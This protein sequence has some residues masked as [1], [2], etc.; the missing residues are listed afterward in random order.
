MSDNKRNKIDSVIDEVIE[1]KR[2][3]QGTR[4][5]FTKFIGIVVL[6]I[7]LFILAIAM[8]IIR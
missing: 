6:L 2:L 4:F 5:L 1:S 8:G 3:R 7:I